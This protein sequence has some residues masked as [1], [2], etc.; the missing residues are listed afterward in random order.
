MFM[1]KVCRGRVA[2]AKISIFSLVF[3]GRNFYILQKT[4]I[5]NIS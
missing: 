3:S 1:F 4:L 5:V 2:G